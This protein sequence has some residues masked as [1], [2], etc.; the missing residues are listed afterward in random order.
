MYKSIPMFEMVIFDM[1]GLLIDTEPYWQATE[2]EVFADYGIKITE[3]MQHAT[4]G[5]R[6]DEQ[7]KYWYNYKPW[8]NPDFKEV[9]NRYNE[10]IREFFEEKAQLMVGAEYILDFFERMG[11]NMALASSSSMELINTFVDRFHFREKFSLLYSAENEDYGKPH[12]AVYLSTAKKMKVHP[13]SCLA[14]EDSLNGV[15]AAK[16][17]QMK[18]VAV[19]DGRHYE[20]PGYGIADLKLRNLNEFSQQKMKSLII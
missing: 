2:Q 12:P 19:P 14:F 16:A 8:N 11:M 15:I 18:V 5:L 10:I 13:S 20:L 6:T 17:A 4:F 1:D 9:E 3:E 7:I